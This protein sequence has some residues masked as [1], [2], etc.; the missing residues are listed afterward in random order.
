[1]IHGATGIALDLCGWTPLA[2]LA[3]GYGTEG[4]PCGVHGRQP[5]PIAAPNI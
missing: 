3:Q 2:G 1:V 5:M 4:H